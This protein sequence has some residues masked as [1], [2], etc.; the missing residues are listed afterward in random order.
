MA[1]VHGLDKLHQAITE[2]LEFEKCCICLEKLQKCVIL[3]PCSHRF[4]NDCILAYLVS[5]HG[6]KIP[7]P[8]CKRL[9]TRR[10]ILNFQDRQQEFEDSLQTLIGNI[11]LDLGFDITSVQPF[12]KN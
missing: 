5:V 1:S 8:L 6:D 3:W 4:C 7:C 11:S 2:A 9:T 10:S 12:K